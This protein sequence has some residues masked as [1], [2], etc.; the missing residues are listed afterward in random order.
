[1]RGAATIDR[2][3]AR[4]YDDPSG[5]LIFTGAR[6]AK[7]YGRIGAGGR[8]RGQLYVHRVVWEHHNG[9]IPEGMV[10]MHRCDVS[11]CCA[12]DHLQVGTYAENTADMVAKG[13]HWAQ[14]P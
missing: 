12:I 6:T 4:C 7:G 2:V 1:M 3:M 5:C 14:K 13:R 8:S 10:V 9:P 11:S